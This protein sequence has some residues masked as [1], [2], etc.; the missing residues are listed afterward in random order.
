MY[1]FDVMVGASPALET[2]NSAPWEP[3]VGLLVDVNWS[4]SPL[5]KSIVRDLPRAGSAGQ[6]DC[7]VGLQVEYVCAVDGDAKMSA[8]MTASRRGDLMER[9]LP[10]V[11]MAG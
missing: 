2:V 5:V 1:H 9:K 7:V 8:A 10:S 6:L 4:D 3:Y 11:N